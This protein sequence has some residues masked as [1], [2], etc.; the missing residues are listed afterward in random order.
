V[1]QLLV[2]S[3]GCPFGTRLGATRQLS[4]YFWISPDALV[5]TDLANFRVAGSKTIQERGCGKP[6]RK[7]GGNPKNYCWQRRLTA[8]QGWRF[9]AELLLNFRLQMRA[10]S[11]N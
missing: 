1:T 5:M 8:R 6:Q 10:S 2:A 7:I 11:C 3:R 4:A 9:F